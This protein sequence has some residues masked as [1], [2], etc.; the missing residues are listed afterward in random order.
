L[1]PVGTGRAFA[2]HPEQWPATGAWVRTLNPSW[3]GTTGAPINARPLQPIVNARPPAADRSPLR[4]DTTHVQPDPLLADRREP[5]RYSGT[6]RVGRNRAVGAE[7][8]AAVLELPRAL[9]PK[10]RYQH[11][12]HDGAGS[13]VRGVELALSFALAAAGLLRP[14]SKFDL[15]VQPSSRCRATA[16]CSAPTARQ[17]RRV[18]PRSTG[19]ERAE[20]LER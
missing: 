6:I 13:R 12:R 10:V 8:L 1:D 5:A 20:T 16:S 7:Q 18:H 9:Q 14:E 4:F 11:P 2:R 15:R 3:V 17:S 19:L